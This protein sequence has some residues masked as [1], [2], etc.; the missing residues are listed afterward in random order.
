MLDIGISEIL[1][2]GAPGSAA[3]SGARDVVDLDGLT[4]NG[5]AGRSCRCRWPCPMG[6]PSPPRFGIWT[7]HDLEFPSPLDTRCSPWA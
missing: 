4:P 7:I 5:S 3:S 2:I 1:L 6:S